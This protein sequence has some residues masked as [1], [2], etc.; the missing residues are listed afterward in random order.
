[1]SSAAR[2]QE[3]AQ[4]KRYLLIVLL[5]AIA[6]AT[7]GCTS[8]LEGDRLIVTPHIT[9]SLDRQ[10]EEL[11]EVSN[12]NEL[13]EA[14]MLLISGHAESGRM[15]SYT[16]DGDI[17]E[18]IYLARSFI[19][20]E[21]PVGAYAVSEITGVATRIVSFS[22]IDIEIEYRRT[23][24]QM[25]SVVYVASMRYL[26]NELLRVL[27][28]YPDE[29]VFRSTMPITEEEIIGMVRETYYQNPRQIVMLPVTVVEVYPE[30]GDDR[31]YELRFGYH[32]QPS[33]LRHYSTSLQ[34][35]V[36]RNA[37]LAVG[38][39]DSD[40]LLSLAEN[41][42]A[43]SVFD[44]GAARMI[45]EHGVQ[46][47]A[48]TAY[49]ALVHGRAVGEGFAMAFKALCDELRFESYV[50]L[51][52]LDGMIHAWNIVRLYGDYYHMDIA[53]CD[54]LGI[55]AAFLKNDEDFATLGYIWDMETTVRCE[56]ELT[57]EDIIRPEEPDDPDDPDDTDAQGDSVSGADELD[58]VPDEALEPPNE[59]TDEPPEE[60]DHAVTT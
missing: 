25:E 57:L 11:V 35:Y 6:A 1:M 40:V 54:L 50:V 27:S 32:E 49:G 13:I 28:D 23:R 15:I 21:D 48:A 20:R 3:G 2:E 24:E 16:Y 42:L 5:C 58:E 18:D 12:L 30:L 10:P 22:E 37:E 14:I 43:A 38:D 26:R 39:S 41:L 17:S 4:L 8:L 52:I 19:M 51:G 36:R 46:N 34:L 44:Q 56:G 45:S 9:T 47:I 59:D 33:I 60:P 53:M 31:I 7:I 29:I 55:E